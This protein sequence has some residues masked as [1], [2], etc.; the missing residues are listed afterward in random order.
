MYVN[1]RSEGWFKLKE[2]FDKDNLRILPDSVLSEQLMSIKYKFRS[3]EQK[4]I[5]S[6]DDMRKDGL[7]SPDRADALMMALYFKDSVF[8][9]RI[10]SHLPRETVSV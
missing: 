7:K 4:M 5:V 9:P 2:M 6:K 8:S 1:A 10:T 3:N